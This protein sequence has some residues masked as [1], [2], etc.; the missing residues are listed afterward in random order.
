MKFTAGDQRDERWRWQ[1]GRAYPDGS[2]EAGPVASSPCKPS[3]AL[4]YPT[5]E[6]VLRY[7]RASVRLDEALHGSAVA[8]APY[9]P[10]E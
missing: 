6:D 3:V 7:W 8:G 2:A 9:K 1:L 10:A 5:G 4:M